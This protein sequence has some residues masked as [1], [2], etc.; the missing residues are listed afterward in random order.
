MQFTNR[1]C[2]FF[3]RVLT[4]SGKFLT[5]EV[6]GAQNCNFAP[7]FSP[8]LG[9]FCLDI[10]HFLDKNFSATT[11]EKFGG[12]WQ[13]SLCILPPATT[14]VYCAVQMESP[15]LPSPLCDKELE[16]LILIGGR[17]SRASESESTRSS[18]ESEPEL[19]AST[20]LP[21]W[22]SSDILTS[23]VYFINLALLCL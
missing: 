10:L 9:L 15:V 3:Y 12:K 18:D 17:L 2:R 8:K 5:V 23:E 19:S 20:Q 16:D 1:C 7:E 6:V 4:G 11:C 21:C 14:L 13:L 22:T